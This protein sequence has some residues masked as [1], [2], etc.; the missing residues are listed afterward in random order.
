M[1]DA[2]EVVKADKTDKLTVCWLAIE[3]CEGRLSRLMS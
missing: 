3:G 1:K 2:V